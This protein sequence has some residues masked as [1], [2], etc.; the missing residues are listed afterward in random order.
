VCLLVRVLLLLSFIANWQAKQ[1]QTMRDHNAPSRLLVAVDFAMSYDHHHL[2]EVQSEHW[3]H[4]T[5]AIFIAVVYLQQIAA[6][7]THFFL[8]QD[9]KH[10]FAFVQHCFSVLIDGALESLLSS[11]CTVADVL[12]WY[13]AAEYRQRYSELKELCV[14]SDG[15]AAQFKQSST[16]YFLSQQAQASAITCSWNFWASCHGL[17]C[18]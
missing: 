17:C 5:T 11:P 15:S 2:Y 1:F 4:G 12:L 3:T 7:E 8:S 18:E 10:D 9:N 16:P 14:W 6:A 13:C